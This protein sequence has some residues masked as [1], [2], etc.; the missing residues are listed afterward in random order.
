[1][2][3]TSKSAAHAGRKIRFAAE[4]AAPTL[5]P[6]NPRRQSLKDKDAAIAPAEPFWSMTLYD[7]ANRS[8]VESQ[9][10]VR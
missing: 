8:V 10:V 4:K 3:N 2:A 6:T 9:A 7:A 1:M 5:R